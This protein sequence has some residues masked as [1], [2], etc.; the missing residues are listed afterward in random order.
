[1]NKNIEYYLSLKYPVELVEIPQDE[2]GGYSAR[3]PLLGRKAFLADGETVEEALGN[4]ESVKR[5][6]FETY[7][8]RGTAI[9]EPSSEDDEDFSGRF[10]VRIPKEL[11]RTLVSKA[12]KNEVS[13]NQYVQFLLTASVVTEGFE[14]VVEKCAV[15]FNQIIEQMQNIEYKFEGHAL[16]SSGRSA[17]KKQFSGKIFKFGEAA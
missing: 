7:L 1:V 6:W 14:S 8:E 17:Q 12:E 4:L 5:E 16:A 13:L 11:H 15:R 3:I 9:P 2:G 10:V